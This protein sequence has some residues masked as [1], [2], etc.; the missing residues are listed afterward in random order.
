M[1]LS[2]AHARTTYSL[3]P[4]MHCLLT[5]A[6]HLELP[7]QLIGRV[8]LHLDHHLDLLRAVRVPREYSVALS[9]A[10]SMV[11]SIVVSIVLGSR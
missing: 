3:L 7:D 4:C 10:L 8:L 11:L 1:S 5:T 2:V 6:T 9:I